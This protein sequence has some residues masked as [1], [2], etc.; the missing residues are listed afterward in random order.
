MRLKFNCLSLSDINESMCQVLD[1]GK[2]YFVRY[3]WLHSKFA[4]NFLGLFI[5]KN[6]SGD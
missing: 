3:K 4:L 5:L 6:S 1:R 2:K